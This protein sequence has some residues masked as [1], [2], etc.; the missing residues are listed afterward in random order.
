M[1]NSLKRF[2]IALLLALMIG[3]GVH[4]AA[5]SIAQTDVPDLPAESDT[6]QFAVI[7]D[8]GKAGPN[9]EAVAEM[10][11]GWEPDFIITTGDNNYDFGAAE[12]IDQNIG[13]YYHIFIAP[14]IGSYGEGA[15]EDAEDNRFFPT[16]GNHDWYTDDAQPYF[17]YFELPGNERYYTFT[18]GTVQFFALNSDYN[19]PDGFRSNSVQAE[20]LQDEL[21][22]S[23]ATW[24]LVYFHV[25][26]YSSGHHGS[27]PVMRWPFADW[28]ASAVLSGHDHIYERLEVDGI[29][30]F[31]NGV[32]GGAIYALSTP[33]PKSEFRF[34]RNYGAMLVT[35]TEMEITFEFY[36]VGDNTT[37]LDRLTLTIDE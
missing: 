14:Y 18:E 19:E 23:T 37:P 29:P 2:C 34:N 24:K 3:L 35:A 28:G 11:I 20:W 16:L 8:Y 31:V 10:V 32:G 12:T 25:A 33:L 1:I 13:Q 6:I 7:G 27:N 26:P 36:S 4:L 17:D 22:D 21:A 9:A 30:Y 15:G 5:P